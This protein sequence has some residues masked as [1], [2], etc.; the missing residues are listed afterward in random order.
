MQNRNRFTDTE[1]KLAVTKGEREKGR[2]K[3]GI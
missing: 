1:S 2:E 3:V